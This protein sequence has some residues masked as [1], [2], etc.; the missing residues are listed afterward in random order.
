MGKHS[1]NPM[2][3]IAVIALVLLAACGKAPEPIAAPAPVAVETPKGDPVEGLR[4]ATRLGCNGCHEKDGA[5]GVFMDSPAAGLVVA[6]NLTERRRLYDDAAF[7]ALLR[8]GKT[9]DGHPPLGMPIH[10]FQYLADD[11]VL[12]VTA[13]LR[14]LP[15][16]TSTLPATK[17]SKDVAQGIADGTLPFLDDVKPDPGNVPP[18]TRPVEPLAL[19]KYLAF[20]TC[21]ECHGRDLDGWGPDDPSPSLVVAKAYTADTFARLMKTGEI[22]TGGKSK[23][24]LMSE[25]AAFRFSSL[26]EAEVSAL[27]LYLDSR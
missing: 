10:M 6:P 27:K 4:V 17:Y 18:A 14:S 7:A 23:S 21:S 13:W 15:D 25:V 19:G 20:T 2:H 3:R 16:V 8:E 9:H 12:D 5:G 11:E 1:G 26:T 22:A 24:G